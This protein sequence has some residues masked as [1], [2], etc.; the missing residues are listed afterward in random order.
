M[1][2]KYKSGIKVIEK[3]TLIT[4]VQI[5]T[6]SAK[7]INNSL[8]SHAKSLQEL[9]AQSEI[10]KLLYTPIQ[11]FFAI[12]IQSSDQYKTSL[13]QINTNHLKQTQALK[14][15]AENLETLMNEAVDKSITKKTKLILVIRQLTSDVLYFIK[16]QEMTHHSYSPGM[17]P[18]TAPVN[19]ALRTA[20]YEH[21]LAHQEKFGVGTYPNLNVAKRHAS[22]NEHT[23]SERT[24]RDI[25]RLH[26]G[27]T[28]F[29][30]MQQK[31]GSK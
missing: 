26:K 12:V 3:R 4:K 23:L 13:K 18:N 15:A 14:S 9:D 16:Q 6:N 19:W 25:K 1:T 10:P 30:Y 22:K 5:A 17:R 7:Q 24:Y 8:E 11:D 29:H 28:L 31:N 21:I 20:V 27:G 2:G